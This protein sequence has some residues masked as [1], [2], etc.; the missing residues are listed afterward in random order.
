MA[1][2]HG[3]AGGISG[4]VPMNWVER[5]IGIPFVDGGRDISGVDCWGLVRLVYSEVLNIDLPS[6]GE[7]SA[8]KLLAISK[9]ISKGQ[10]S[11]VEPD[12]PEPLDGVLMRH[13]SRTSLIGH[14]GI[15]ADRANVL[16]IEE[17]TASCVVPLNHYS[18]RFRVAGFRRY[19]G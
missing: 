13:S 1:W 11:W 2:K 3:N 6:Y 9:A 5:Y 7:I 14:M 8:Q 10:E 17:S 4:V 16:H 18:V 12:T 15:L 19:V